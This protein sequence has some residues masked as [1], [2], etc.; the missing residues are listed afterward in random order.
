LVR[1]EASR[2]GEP[3]SYCFVHRPRHQAFF[4]EV[5][6]KFAA[7]QLAEEPIMLTQLR[8]PQSSELKIGMKLIVDFV[9]VSDT[10]QRPIWRPVPSN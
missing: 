10:T 5:S 7:V 6:I 8:A 4:G 3:F 9:A 1:V 2:R